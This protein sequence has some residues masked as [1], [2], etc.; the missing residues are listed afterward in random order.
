M[1]FCQMSQDVGKRRCQIARVHS[2][3]FEV[4]PDMRRV[5]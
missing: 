4:I 3:L 5:D 1:N 2:F